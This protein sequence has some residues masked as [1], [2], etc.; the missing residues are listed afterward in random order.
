MT[1]DAKKTFFEKY[2][3][4]F[5]SWKSIVWNIFLITIG[6]GIF[7][8]GLKAVAVQQS[9]LPGGLFG[10]CSLIYYYTY[11]L[12]PGVWYFFLN[13]PLFLFAWFKVSRR[14]FIYSMLAAL[15]NSAGYPLFDVQLQIDNQLYA[16]I[17]A[18]MIMG[19]GSGIILRS[20]GSGGG[21]DVIA[22]YL[23]QKY[24]L[25]IGRFYLIV[26]GCIFTASA[27]IL[28]LDLIIA[29][30]IMVFISSVSI[31]KVLSL[32]SERKLVLIVS[33]KTPLIAEEISRTL[34]QG[35][36]FLHGHGMFTR[37]Q[38][39]VLMAVTNNIQ[40]R[41]LEEIVFKYDENALF[42]VEN[43]FSVLGA[44]FSRRKIY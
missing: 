30:M 3:K 2:M 8:F 42:I 16:A 7:I 44:N 27:F 26:N 37:S 4:E 20:L 19:C 33:N 14:F 40:L 43:T 6:S 11:L 34:H 18:G 24:N 35:G 5:G 31:D 29:S 10:L 22:V 13:I 28:N 39:D 41:R 1:T 21:A 12:D 38:K 23:F 25:G 9:F 15:I 32:F 17:V 36:T